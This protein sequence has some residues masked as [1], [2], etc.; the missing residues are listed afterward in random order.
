MQVQGGQPVA[1]IALMQSTLTPD[2][3][4]YTRVASFPTG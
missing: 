3:P 4:E 1:A 2:G